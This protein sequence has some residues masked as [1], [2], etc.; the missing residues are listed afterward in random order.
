METTVSVSYGT[1]SAWTACP[2]HGVGL[3][4]TC[5]QHECSNARNRAGIVVLGYCTRRGGFLGDAH[6]ADAS[7]AILWVARH[8]G[9]LPATAPWRA[10]GYGKTREIEHIRSARIRSVYVLNLRS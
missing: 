3:A 1:V 9:Q 5:P 8:V 4:S 6:A 2:K 7:P 10:A